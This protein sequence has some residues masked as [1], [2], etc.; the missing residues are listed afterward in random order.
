MN[1]T[2]PSSST[3]QTE[4]DVDDTWRRPHYVTPEEPV[5]SHPHYVSP[6]ETV[7]RHPHRVL[8]KSSQNLVSVMEVVSDEHNDV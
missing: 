8:P 6:V 7:W 1:T 5:W 2:M 3:C 4:I